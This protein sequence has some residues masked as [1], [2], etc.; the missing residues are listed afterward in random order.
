MTPLAH[1]QGDMDV[2]P[3]M[4]T[5]MTVKGRTDGISLLK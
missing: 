1:K 3:L 5:G 4:R 2:R